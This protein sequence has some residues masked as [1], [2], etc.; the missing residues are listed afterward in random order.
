[1]EYINNEIVSKTS[2]LNT[3][4]Q[5]NTPFKH[6]A[7]TNF[8]IPSIADNLLS[9]FPEFDSSSKNEFGEPSLKHVVTD[10]KSISPFYNSFYN[11]ISSNTFLNYVTELTGITDLI[12]DP[13]MF[14]G[15]T[16][17]NQHGQKLDVHVDFN[18]DNFNNHRRL[19]MLIYLNRE[20]ELDWGGGIEL[21]SNPKDVE[22]D[23]IITTNVLFNTCVIFETNEYSWHGF[24]E[25]NLPDHLKNTVSRKCISIYLYTKNRPEHE[26]F[27]KHGTYYIQY[28]AD[29][30]KIGQVIDNRI[31]SY[32][33]N[34]INERNK[35]IQTYQ[36]ENQQLKTKLLKYIKYNIK[37][38]GFIEIIKIDSILND[39]WI[40]ENCDIFIKVHKPIVKLQ[41]SFYL[42]S[43]LLACNN[44]NNIYINDIYKQTNKQISENQTI[45]I[46]HSTDC[47]FKITIKNKN[48]IKIQENEIYGGLLVS[49]FAI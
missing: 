17:N 35:W 26:I 37:T 29:Q 25:I 15:G 42:P 16:H 5:N 13:T 32:I 4:F 34:H 41:L 11:Y 31:Y 20:W 21:H 47:D 46:N 45:E 38:I 40:G 7:I 48:L 28:P 33:T 39:N 12:F 10:I 19:N 2:Q 8:L 6:I 30:L 9:D 3:I 43:H 44:E 22:H 23:N 14:G 27:G 36:E 24:K 1:M 49:I 18:Y